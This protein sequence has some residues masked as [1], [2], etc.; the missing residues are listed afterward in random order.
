METTSQTS[1]F[2]LKGIVQHTKSKRRGLVTE[3]DVDIE[4]YDYDDNIKLSEGEKALAVQ[5][6]DTGALGTVGT[7]SVEPLPGMEDEFEQLRQQINSKLKEAADLILEANR[8]SKEG[9]AGRVKKDGYDVSYYLEDLYDVV[10]IRSAM[11]VAGWR[12]SSWNC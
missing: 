9:G 5:W 8:M 4:D 10:C 7:Y 12:T 11:N 3:I 6:L 2:K 1:Q